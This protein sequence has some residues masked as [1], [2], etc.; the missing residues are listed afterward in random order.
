ML[1]SHVL[2]RKAF[3][4]VQRG[5]LLTQNF[6]SPAYTA[7]PNV[8]NTLY[9]SKDEKDSC[10]V[11]LVAHM[12]KKPSRSIVVDANEMLVRMSHRGGCGCEPN[13]GDGA[14]ML[15]G[16]P[17]TYYQRVVKETIGAELGSANSYGAGI[18]FMPKSDK[19]AESIKKVFEA[20]CEGY[21]FKVIG[22]RP[23]VTGMIY[24]IIHQS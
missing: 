24:R 15:V 23:I 13:A 7:F 16:M 2:H 14:G 6:S 17:H 20:Q 9:N 21:G 8:K 10:G 22:W 19:A 5:R 11:G 1:R 4:A 18:I 3:L 12:K